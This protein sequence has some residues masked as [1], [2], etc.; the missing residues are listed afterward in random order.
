MTPRKKLRTTLAGLA[1]VTALALGG[2]APDLQPSGLTIH[3]VFGHY[4]DDRDRPQSIA[5]RPS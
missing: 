4:H 1:S 3:F 5:I 2:L